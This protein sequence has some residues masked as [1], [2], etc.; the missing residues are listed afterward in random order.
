MMIVQYMLDRDLPIEIPGIGAVRNDFTDVV[1]PIALAL[2]QEKQV[3]EQI[4]A[5]FHAARSEG[6]PLGEQF[7]LWFLKEQVEEVASATTLLTVAQRAGTNLFDLE[8]YVAREQVGDGG[9]SLDAPSAAGG[10]L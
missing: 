3:T 7:L 4:E 5:I 8:N 9:E 6:D 10:A 2:A 1:E